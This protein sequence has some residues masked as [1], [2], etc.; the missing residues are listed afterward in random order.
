MKN[1]KIH[2]KTGSV[3]KNGQGLFSEN[4]PLGISLNIAFPL[5]EMSGNP[6]KDFYITDKGELLSYIGGGRKQVI[7]YIQK[8]NFTYI[9]K[10][11]YANSNKFQ[12]PGKLYAAFVQLKEK[13]DLLVF[14]KEP[15]D[16]CVFP[17]KSEM[18]SLLEEYKNVGIS[19]PPGIF[20]D[21][22]RE[23]A[24]GGEKKTHCDHGK[25]RLG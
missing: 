16:F 9:N 19:E 20:R 21:L 24:R 2:Q 12:F 23:Y 15:I 25:N 7:P 18:D 14:L 4:R 8:I 1:A 11:G 6:L 13:K 17:T 10:S 3:D 22:W 5:S